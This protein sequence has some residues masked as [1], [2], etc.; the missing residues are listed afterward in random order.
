[1]WLRR[2]PPRQTGA[3]VA[4]GMFWGTITGITSFITHSGSLPIQAYLLPQRLPKLAF[5]GTMAIAFAVGNLAKLP[6][7][8]ELGKL[9]SLDWAL[10]I[11]LVAVGM[12][13]T[14]MGRFAT[15]ILS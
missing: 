12:I 4:A 14:R 2:G 9:G 3:T 7:Y 5:A 10:T 13:G 6:A 11:A 8:W 1:S 15:L